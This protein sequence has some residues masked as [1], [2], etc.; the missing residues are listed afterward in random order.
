MEA[1][2][3]SELLRRFRRRRHLTQEELAERAG[4]SSNS[5]SLLERGLTQA[6]Q[7]ATV[8]LLC[9]ALELA[10][11]EATT[12][13]EMAR[14]ATPLDGKAPDEA[15][16]V[17]GA[18]SSDTALPVLP[19]PL[20]SLIGRE[21]DVDSLL[22]L[23]SQPTLR[24]LTLT[25][26]A[27]VGKTRLLLDLLAQLQVEAVR[28]VVFVSLVTVQDAERVLPAI[29]R[30]LGI[31][32]SG[33]A[34]L[35]DM[36]IRRLR[37]RR[38]V[39]ALDNFE[40][41]L[42]AARSLVELLVACPQITAVVTSRQALNVRGERCYPVAPLALP[43][44]DQMDSIEELRSAPTVALFVERASA[45]APTFDLATL[46]D[47]RQ[48][49]NICAQ[50]DGL[51]L[52]IELAAAQV[53]TFSL[54]ELHERLTG[55]AFLGVLTAGPQDLADHQRTMRS[56]I[57]WSY[58]LLAEPER[59]LFRW[60]G[61]FV[62]SVRI[63]AV[64]AIT[65]L[66]DDEA[67][68]GLAVLVAANLVRREEVAEGTPRY[69]QLVTLRA[70]AQE[71]L[72]AE[73]EW[74]AARK[75]HAQY[76]WRLTQLF[77]R[78]VNEQPEDVV[79]QLASEYVNVRAALTWA[80]ETGDIPFGMRMVGLLWLLWRS[81]G[82]HLEGLDWLER[83]LSRAD[84]PQTPEEQET[85]ALVL[86][87][88][89]ALSHWLDRFERAREAGE[90][91]LV[92]YQA[93]GN[94]ADIASAMSNLANPLVELRE[95]DRAL[96]L[97]E[98]CLAILRDL[99]DRLGI[100]FPLLNLGSL[101]YAMDK[102]E[103][104]LVCYEESLAISQAMGEGDWAR[105]T[106]WANVGEAYLALDQPTRTLQVVEPCY[107]LLSRQRD[108]L[109][110]ATTAFILGRAHWRLNDRTLA[111][112]YLDEAT[113]LYDTVGSSLTAVRARYF[114]ASV[115]LDL[116]DD[117]NAEG[118]AWRDLAQGLNGL[119]GQQRESVVLWML[120]ERAGTLARRR[121]EPEM[122]ARLL[123]AA[124]AHR[125]GVTG[126]FEPAERDLR[127][128]E[129][130]AL[131]TPLGEATLECRLREGSALSAAEAFEAIRQALGIIAFVA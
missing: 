97:F 43:T 85:H 66:G 84:P 91:A 129:M 21:C 105:S 116:G 67:H 98:E 106:T 114:H 33:A 82:Q 103:K 104:A 39:L 100:I 121:G 60:L 24:L 53:Q 14:H 32:E 128:R 8:R 40:Q 3:F 71:R 86:T 120:A 51:P 64:K 47:A 130:Q 22:R 36:L 62:G 37:E 75:A 61:V 94:R 17:V 18:T 16:S 118:E 7:R 124:L 102:P 6:P 65:T 112:A 46:G 12:F 31:E 58:D 52:A 88:I 99:D 122:A 56:T 81:Y 119:V 83:F 15:S 38:L 127:S 54:R 2:D 108:T 10:P 68:N 93:L 92:L 35:H 25:G 29:A 95:Y 109:G 73:H 115:M 125:D 9:A 117:A 44:A 77:N 90:A 5:V 50:L 123:G 13:T 28:D 27:G 26:A 80:W 107:H 72:R 70:Y 30:A 4:L 69:T 41:V 76:Y 111:L 113:D 19:V 1:S 87:G 57:A 23:L 63:E 131:S 55:P 48:V 74:D 126:I 49:A 110:V 45:V 101:Y 42:P 20:T 79:E 34:P 96:T 59:R 78:H 89:M 11:E